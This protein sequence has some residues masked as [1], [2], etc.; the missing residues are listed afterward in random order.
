MSVAARADLDP[1]TEPAGELIA[2]ATSLRPLI[3]EH[4]ATGSRD[5]RVTPE[6]VSALESNG[7]LK[8]TVPKRYGGAEVNTRTLVDVLIELARGDG[9]TAWSAMLLN[10]ANWF[11]TTWPVRAQD[12]IW[13]PN[14]DA[15]GC[16]ILA[17]N[18]TVS[19]RRVEG[20]FVVSGKWPYASGSF[21]ATYAGVGFLAPQAD[22]TNAHVLGIAHPGEWSIERSWFPIGMRG[23]GSDTVVLDEAFIPDHRVQ[24]FGRMVVGDYASELRD[25]EAQAR[26]AFLPKGTIIF[27][28]IQIGLARAA[29]ELAVERMRSKG[30]VGTAYSQA[31]NS[32]VHQVSVAQAM[33]KIDAAELLAHRSC[34]DIDAAA[35]AGVY[36]DEVNRARVR[37]DTGQIVSFVQ[38]A[39]DLL[40][41][42]TGS[43]SFV[44]NN[45]LSRIYQ[46][47]GMAGSHVHA[48][49]GI[50]LDVYGRLLLGSDGDL[51]VSV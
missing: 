13:G 37:N 8:L 22:G 23:T 17:P 43:S 32:P 15:R 25:E 11:T 3:R 16:V 12:E 47:V 7:L 5:G 29:Y 26:A 19:S 14:P 41:K 18:P 10:V 44:E 24:H 42:S 28:A 49:P 51:P 48:T 4:A 36:L 38:E 30:V 45:P 46:D 33:A 9:S 50:A 6:V 21:T 34:H 27:G 20:G 2:R 31:R 39:V 35:I 1:T 40:L